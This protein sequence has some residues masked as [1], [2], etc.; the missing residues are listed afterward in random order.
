MAHS[1]W[2]TGWPNC[3]RSNIVTLVRRDGLRLPVHRDLADL[4]TILMDLTEA[5]GYDIRPDWSWGYACRPIANTSTPSNHSWGTAVDINA[6]ANPR[7]RRGL[8][9]VT[10][11]PPE[12]VRLWEDNGFRWGGRYSWPDPMHFEFMGTTAQA[13]ATAARIRAFL[14]AAAPAPPSGGKPTPPEDGYPGRVERGDTGRAVRVWQD[15]LRQRG[16]SLAV[17]GVFG[18]VTEAAVRDWQRRHRPPLT[19]DGIA[20]PMTWHSVLFA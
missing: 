20:G 10:D 16:Y 4:V 8:P 5:V 15:V 13:R 3:D 14:G 12:V 17:D 19:V 18:P 2:G 7:R 1:S 9:M 6:P 11:I